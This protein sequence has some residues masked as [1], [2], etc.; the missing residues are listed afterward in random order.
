MREIIGKINSL[1]LKKQR[2]LKAFTR[3]KELQNECMDLIDK[4]ERSGIELM[5]KSHLLASD[6]SDSSL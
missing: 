6:L 2:L 4:L 1:V 5:D 3:F